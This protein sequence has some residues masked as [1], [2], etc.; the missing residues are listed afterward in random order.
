MDTASQLQPFAKWVLQKKAEKCDITAE[1]G[2]TVE[3]HYRVRHGCQLRVHYRMRLDDCCRQA[4][5]NSD[6]QD[7][8]S[9][10]Q[11]REAGSMWQRAGS[12]THAAS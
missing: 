12:N 11:H 2:D 7:E 9:R 3:V 5:G 4:G 1:N 10:Q 6:R 8:C